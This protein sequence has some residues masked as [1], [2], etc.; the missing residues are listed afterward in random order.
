MRTS[1]ASIVLRCALIALLAVSVDRRAL[2]FAQE[3]PA[4]PKAAAEAGDALRQKYEERLRDQRVNLFLKRAKLTTAVAILGS[5]YDVP[6]AVDPAVNHGSPEAVMIHLEADDL[7]LEAALGQVME[8][9]GLDLKL[10]W[11]GDKFLIA[12]ADYQSPAQ[13]PS[14]ADAPPPASPPPPPPTDEQIQTAVARLDSPVWSE[15]EAAMADLEKAGG[16][17][18]PALE[19]ALAAGGCSPET[20]WR[21]ERLVA[22]ARWTFPPDMAARLKGHMD[23]FGQKDAAA[24]RVVV[25]QAVSKAGMEHAVVVLERV[26]YYDPDAQVRLTAVDLSLGLKLA[27]PGATT[28]DWLIGIA[29]KRRD[30]PLLELL[31]NRF[32]R[33]GAAAESRKCMALAIDLHPT[34]ANLNAFATDAYGRGDWEEAGRYFTRLLA[35]P[36][37]AA[38]TPPAGLA[39]IRAKMALCAA[40]LAVVAERDKAPDAPARI[41]AERAA[42]EALV[43]DAATEADTLREVGGLLIDMERWAPAA[44]VLGALIDGHPEEFD[45]LDQFRL[46]R[47]LARAGQPQEAERH[48]VSAKAR[49]SERAAADP[50]VTENELIGR[51][52]KELLEIVHADPRCDQRIEEERAALAALARKIDDLTTSGASRWEINGVEKLFVWKHVFLARHYASR[53]EAEKA[54]EHLNAA[55]RRVFEFDYHLNLAVIGVCEALADDTAVDM[56][57]EIARDTTIAPDYRQALEALDN[58]DNPRAVAFW[59]DLLR[60]EEPYLRERASRALGMLQAAAALET[61]MALIDE[62]HLPAG[63]LKELQRRKDCADALV[64]IENPAGAR[65]AIRFYEFYETATRKDNDRDTD[66]NHAMAWAVVRDE[67]AG[68]AIARR[69]AGQQEEADAA[70]AAAFAAHRNVRSLADRVLAAYENDLTRVTGASPDRPSNESLLACNSVAWCFAKCGHRLPEALRFAAR[71]VAGAPDTTRFYFHDTFAEALF[72]SGRVDDAIAEEE[73]ALALHP[74]QVHFYCRQLTRFRAAKEKGATFPWDQFAAEEEAEEKARQEAQGE[75]PTLTPAQRAILEKNTVPEWILARPLDPGK[76]FYAGGV[77]TA[78]G[79]LSL[80]MESA[81]AAARAKLAEVLT[82]KVQAVLSQCLREAAVP[83]ATTPVDEAQVRNVTRAVIDTVMSGSQIVKREP[84]PTGEWYALA[85]I[86]VDDVAIQLKMASEKQIQAIAE[87]R[88]QAFAE[89][90][91]LLKEASEK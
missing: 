49:A 10:V 71:A 30:A 23:G 13:K 74:R 72:R 7:P 32:A 81:N 67:L 3:A 54:Y 20:R 6:I 90:E 63:D 88:D 45:P 75:A 50:R 31:A 79:N 28:A 22:S 51:I 8:S 87:N 21:A 55:R 70:R 14:A 2:L 4:D 62:A 43:G 82:E 24:R 42:V 11:N 76:A 77:G 15:R 84:A 64:Q 80:A 56:L 1:H 69:A 58:I 85:S 17:A 12:P 66:S 27:P 39:G 36:G 19:K 34:P 33:S 40:R 53:G 18:V 16:A 60:A 73:K 44:R 86:S 25:S 5:F 68:A 65:A 91:R 48:L 47:A 57:A 9:S 35:L 78:K 59:M 29:L 83:G 37:V 38:E 41:E 52:D 89:L 61:L 26:L 46:G